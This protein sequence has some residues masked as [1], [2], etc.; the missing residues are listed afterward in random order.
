MWTKSNQNFE[1]QSRRDHSGIHNNDLDEVDWQEKAMMLLCEE[2]Y[3]SHKMHFGVCIAHQ[4]SKAW[5]SIRVLWYTIGGSLKHTHDI[6]PGG[7]RAFYLRCDV[8]LF[9]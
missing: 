3:D 7:E 5:T 1:R 4:Q 8:I 2:W 9:N 6:I